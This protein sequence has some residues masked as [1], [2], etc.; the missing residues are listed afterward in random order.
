MKVDIET[1]DRYVSTICEYKDTKK[2]NV[3]IHMLK[4]KKKSIR[5]KKKIRSSSVM[6]VNINV[7][8]KINRTYTKEPDIKLK[9]EEMWYKHVCTKKDTLRAHININPKELEETLLVCHS[10]DNTSTKKVTLRMHKGVKHEAKLSNCDKCEYSCTKNEVPVMHK[11]W[12]SR[13]S[14]ET[15]QTECTFEAVCFRTDYIKSGN[16]EL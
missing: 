2:K 10:C 5:R 14:K 4:T 15:L 13:T 12:R 9:R 6:S 3:K 16:H 7:L 8:K 1:E 11:V